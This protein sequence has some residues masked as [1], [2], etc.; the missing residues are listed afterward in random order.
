MIWKKKIKLDVLMLSGCK[1]NQTSADA[2]FNNRANGALTSLFIKLYTKYMGDKYIKNV[3]Y[4]L[5]ELQYDV[6][7]KGF[8]QIPQLSSE[9]TFT[10][11]RLFDL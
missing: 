4:F 7:K 1:D 11:Y 3:V 5:S 10:Q 6:K 8:N 9:T 2:T